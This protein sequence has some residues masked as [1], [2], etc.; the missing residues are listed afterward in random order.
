MPELP[1][2]ASILG[3]FSVI[4]HFPDRILLF[5]EIFQEFSYKK[6]DLYLHLFSNINKVKTMNDSSK[7]NKKDEEKL[8]N[9]F[10]NSCKV[11]EEFLDEKEEMIAEISSKDIKNF[12]DKLSDKGY[13]D[14]HLKEYYEDFEG[15]FSDSKSDGSSSEDSNRE[16]D[17]DDI[18]ISYLKESKSKIFKLFIDKKK[19]K[20]LIC[21]YQASQVECSRNGKLVPEVGS[22]REKDIISWFSYFMNQDVKFDINNSN[23]EDVIIENKNTSIKH[24]SNKKPNS[25][26]IKIKWTVNRDKQKEFLDTFVFTCDLMIIYVRFDIK[27]ISGNI[28]IIY[29]LKNILNEH[30]QKFKSEQKSPF[31]LLNG[32]SRGIEFNNIFFEDIIKLSEFNITI[33][34]KNISCMYCNPIE[35]RIQLLKII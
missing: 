29:I 30:K 13:F 24:S 23:E 7:L 22:S 33:K 34:F 25:S 8:C 35:K 10:G 21:L 17:N 6:N 26:G 1:L 11:S 15:Y 19:I 18:K 14:V 5:G 9:S 28:Q 2:F 12:N 32:N 20:K 31:K 16:Y 3:T 27:L 4:F